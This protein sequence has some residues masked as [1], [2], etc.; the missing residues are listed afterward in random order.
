MTKITAVT[1]RDIRFPTSR[2]LDGSDAMNPDPDYSAAY[3][4]LQTDQ[5]GLEGH[6][7]T[8]TLGRGTELCVAA[9]EALA[10]AVI[11]RTLA[12]ITGDM[13]AFWR[14][15][16]EYSQLR[17]IGPEKGVLHLATAAVVNAALGPVGARRGQAG[18]AAG[19]RHDARGIRAP[20]RFPLH[21]R[22][23]DAGRGA[24]HPARQPGRRKDCASPRW[25]RTAIP[26]YTT[27]AGWLG[28]SD[29]KVRRLMREA[30]RQGWTTSRSRS[31][32][33]SPTTDAAAGRCARRSAPTAS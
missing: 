6:G 26:A 12:D 24:R 27:S 10:P 32:A 15:L 28:Y 5:P 8:F 4:V 1:I 21:H 14:S 22:R 11:G 23:A 7:L 33:T 31:A 18:V 2:N 9:A 29:D 25:S 13:G 20:D 3:V 19:G 17:W 16:T 30:M